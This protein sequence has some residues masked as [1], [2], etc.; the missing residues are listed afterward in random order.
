MLQT[1]ILCPFFNDEASLAEFLPALENLSAID[2]NNQLSILIVNDGS[3][4][5]KFQTKLPYRVIHLHRNIGHQKAIAVGLAYAYRHLSF[6]QII[7]MDC[8]GED[9]P[10][11]IPRLLQTAGTEHK[12]VVAKRV[13]RQEGKRFRFFY[14]VY[15]LLFF[16]LTGKKISFGNFMLL[17]KKEVDKLVFYNEIWSHLAGAILRSGIPYITISS[18][19]GK[20]YG[21]SSKMDFTSLLLHG[22]GAIG[23]FIQIV[24]IRLLIFSL[25]MVAISLIAILIILFI[26]LFTTRAIPGWATTAVSSML[27]ILLQS[28]LLSLFTL[29]CYLLLRG[30][31]QFIPA[32]HFTDY[33]Q[34]VETSDN[35]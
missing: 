4:N 15:K 28:F 21:G 16:L 23:V 2:K 7:T 29:F 34:S 17:P 27:I 8:D 13:S 26:K 32:I 25:I 22:L 10:E 5:L 12:I 6:D 35:E 3:P 1:I 31:R 18:H 20:R 33:V 14:K 24:A 11:D 19:R 9:K 30:Q